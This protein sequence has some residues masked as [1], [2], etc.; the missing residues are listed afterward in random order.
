[1]IARF[2]KAVATVPGQVRG[3]LTKDSSLTGVA[4]LSALRRRTPGRTSSGPARPATALLL[5]HL[6]TMI[7]PGEADEPR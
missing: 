2:M 3:T 4:R 5:V 1:M 6:A 7:G